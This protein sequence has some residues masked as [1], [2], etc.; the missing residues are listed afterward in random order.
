MAIRSDIMTDQLKREGEPP[1]GLL[2]SPVPQYW[3]TDTEDW[4]KV[5]G[6]NGAPKTMLVDKN[7]NPIGSDEPIPVKQ[8]GSIDVIEKVRDVE[9]AAG[10]TTTINTQIDIESTKINWIGVN[11]GSTGSHDY[12]LIVRFRRDGAVGAA[13][14][15]TPAVNFSSGNSSV[16]KT[17]KINILGQLIDVRI[18]NQ[19]TVSRNYDVDIIGGDL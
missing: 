11:S 9:V 12:D 2:A 14:T 17:D 1:A 4:A 13:T 16:N 19:D 5:K 6:R 10:A 7:G 18:N 3:D 15:V 8:T